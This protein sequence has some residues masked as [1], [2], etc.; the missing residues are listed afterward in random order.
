MDPDGLT[1]FGE[2]ETIRAYASARLAESGERDETARALAAWA[3]SE[4]ERVAADFETAADLFAAR[5][6]DA[7]Q[8]N[9]RGVLEWALAND[10]LTALRVA[11]ALCQWWSVRGRY[12]EGHTVLE[13]AFSQCD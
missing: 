13:R 4:A 11:V 6:M 5:W 2:L 12:D 7:E 8:D 1:R 10:P 9:L 3:L